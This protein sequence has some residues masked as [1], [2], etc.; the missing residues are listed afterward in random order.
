M[1][2]VAVIGVGIVGASAG[3][4]LSR[5]GARMV[6]ID[7]GQPGEGV[8]NWSFSWIN[9]NN[10]TSRRSYFDLN[11]A[12]VAAYRELAEIIGPDSWWFPNG[13]LW[14]ADDPV[15]EARLL[16]TA[17]LL[18]SWDYRVE[19]RT[20]AEVRRILEPAVAIPDGVPVVYYPDEACVHG[21]H[22]VRRLVGQAVASGAEC[23]FGAT[24]R[25]IGTAGDG[26]IRTVALS[27]GS[28]LDV[29]IVVNAAGPCASRV[30]GFVARSLPMP[31]EPGVVVRLRFGEDAAAS[32]RR[33]RA[34]LT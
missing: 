28:R 21:W 34:G 15:A 16:K 1:S 7:E 20:G 11:V 12:D 23:R 4:N 13:H 2:T 6:F 14:W 25:D 24:V 33:R 5:R 27:D 22:L 9:A 29:D 3:W 19:V 8:T 26:S 30:A 18:T 32:L 31:R 17:E 10:K